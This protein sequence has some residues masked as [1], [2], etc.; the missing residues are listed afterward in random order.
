MKLF[1]ISMSTSL[2]LFASQV[3]SHPT[4]SKGRICHDY[5]IPVNVTNI[6]LV[7]S[8]DRFTSNYNVVDFSNGLSGWSGAGALHLFSNATQVTGAYT[9]GATSCPPRNRTEN[10]KTILLA[11]H[12]LGY[13][14]RHFFH[15]SYSN[16]KLTSFNI[17]G[18]WGRSRKIQF[19]RL[20]D[21]SRLFRLFLRRPRNW[22]ISKV[23]ISP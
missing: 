5:S 3:S 20:R 17:L 4:K 7:A 19:R 14:R 18:L 12:G 21:I 6:A 22:N 1:C 11:S 16:S 15:R 2:F 9:T 23:C 10:E 13:D 8:Y